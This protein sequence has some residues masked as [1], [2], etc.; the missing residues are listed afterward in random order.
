MPKSPCTL[1]EEEEEELEEKIAQQH[2]YKYL[3]HVRAA[4][5]V[6]TCNCTCDREMYTNKFRNLIWDN[7][8]LLVN[9]LHHLFYIHNFPT[10]LQTTKK[11]TAKNIN[12][13]YW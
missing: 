8:L 4:D 7:V 10:I 1:K 11:I 3:S 6:G 9:V 12:Y 5:S 2:A 13:F